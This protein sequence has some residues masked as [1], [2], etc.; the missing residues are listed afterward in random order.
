MFL[1]GMDVFFCVISVHCADTCILLQEIRDTCIII[2]VILLLEM[3]VF[4]VV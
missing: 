3:L 1:D 2:K 4:I